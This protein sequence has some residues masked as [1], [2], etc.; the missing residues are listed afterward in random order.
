MVRPRFLA[1]LEYSPVDELVL[2]ADVTY[3][4]GRASAGLGC[5]FLLIPQLALR[6]GVGTDPLRFG[7]GFGVRVGPVGLDYAYGFH[8]QLEESHRLG[9]TAAWP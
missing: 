9:V 1:G 4:S 2:A 3:C 5:E 7:G 6:A 8:P